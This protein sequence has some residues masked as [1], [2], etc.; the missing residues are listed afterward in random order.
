M[1]ITAKLQPDTAN[2]KKP[3]HTKKM[4][5]SQHI[6]DETEATINNTIKLNLR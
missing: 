2:V 4:C 6:P 3:L 1:D 5:G